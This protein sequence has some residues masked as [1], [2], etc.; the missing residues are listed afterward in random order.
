MELPKFLRLRSIHAAMNA[1]Y[2][3]FFD[4]GMTDRGE[5]HHCSRHDVPGATLWTTRRFF[6]RTNRGVAGSSDVLV[7]AQKDEMP[8]LTFGGLGAILDFSQHL[9]SNQDRAV[10]KIRLV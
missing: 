7:Q 8:H 9:R 6:L 5:R 10:A 2:A 3:G 4:I 1:E